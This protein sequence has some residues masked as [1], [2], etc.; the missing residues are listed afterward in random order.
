MG[1]FDIFFKKK[2]KKTVQPR[3]DVFSLQIN[4]IVTYDLE[5]YL[6]I[7]KLGYSDSG[8]KWIAYHLKGDKKNIWLAVEQDDE[9]ELGIYERIPT[10]ITDVKDRLD[11]NGI[12]YYLEEHGFA[13]ITEVV[14]QAGA[15]VGQQVEYWDF[16]S[17]DE[18]HYLSVEKWGSDLEISYGYPISLKEISWLAG[19]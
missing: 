8:Y 2:E 11:I 10:Q 6:V 12:R 13:R 18:E 5:D 14:G 19:S 9:L 3:R 15:V 17:D 1:L 7:G 4:D 16:E